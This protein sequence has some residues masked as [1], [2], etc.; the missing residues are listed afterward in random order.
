MS[1]NCCS[2]SVHRFKVAYKPVSLFCGHIGLVFKFAH[3]P[4]VCHL[5]PKIFTVLC[6]IVL[7]V[8]GSRID[9]ERMTS[10][11]RQKDRLDYRE[12]HRTGR[13]VLKDYNRLADLVSSMASEEEKLKRKDKSL[14]LSITECLGENAL[15]MF[16]DVEDIDDCVLEMKSLRDRYRNVHVDLECEIGEEYKARFSRDYTEMTDRISEYIKAANS[17]KKFVRIQ[18]DEKQYEREKQERFEIEERNLK[19]RVDIE[20]KLKDQQLEV[21]E[22]LRIEENEEKLKQEDKLAKEKLVIVNFNIECLNSIKSTLERVFGSDLNKEDDYEILEKRKNLN[23]IN[24]EFRNFSEISLEILKYFPSDL[25]YKGLRGKISEE[26]TNLSRLHSI[27]IVELQEEVTK[28]DLNKE[29]LSPMSVLNIK[30]D[31][32]T[33]YDSAVDIYTF[34]DNFEKLY[35]SVTQKKRL[36]DLLKNNYLDGTAL[37]LVK[38]IE[39]IDEIWKRLK[40]AFGNSELLLRKKLYETEKCGPIWKIREPKGLINA[41]SKL[42]NAMTDL[43]NLAAKHSIENDLY[44]SSTFNLMY[45]LIGEFR[46]KKFISETIGQ[47]LCKKEKWKKLQEFLVKEI[48]IL[49]EILL[50]EKNVNDNEKKEKFKKDHSY[51]TQDKASEVKLKCHICGKNDHKATKDFKNRD[52]IQYFACKTFVEMSPKERFEKLREK[53]LCHQC[54]APGAY[55]KNDKRSYHKSGKCF[56]KFVCKDKLHNKYNQK[57]HVLVC[58]EHKNQ[59]DDLFEKYKTAEIVGKIQTLEDFSKQIKLSY[60]SGANEP[61]L[62]EENMEVKVPLYVPPP[63]RC[64]I[65]LERESK[66]LDSPNNSLSVL[67]PVFKSKRAQTDKSTIDSCEPEQTESFIYM[68]QR[69]IVGNNEFS[70]FFDSGCGDLVN[71]KSAVDK[72]GSDAELQVAGPL[73]LNGV[74]NVRTISRHGI[75]RITLPLYNGNK[76]ILCGITLD[77]VTARFPTYTLSGKVQDDIHREFRSSGGNPINLPKLFKKVGGETDFMLGIKYLKYFPREVFY[78]PSGLTIYESVFLNPDGSRGV[79]GGPHSVFTAIEQQYGNFA[80]KAYLN[81]QLIIV[82]QGYQINPDVSLLNVKPDK[83]LQKDSLSYGIKILK[84][85]KAF[86]NIENAGT[87][88]NYRC[89]SCRNCADCKKGERIEL[90]SL[91]DEYEQNLIDKSIEVDIVKGLTLARLPFVESPEKLVPNKSQALS[92]YRSQVNKL[93]R[94]PRIRKI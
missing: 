61:V 93:N 3:K 68:L 66:K 46:K 69:I 75:H 22:K 58:E 77:Q 24:E 53:D 62:K 83:D 28:R 5:Y 23:V 87:E 34:Q 7:I 37:V 90:I 40:R 88:V 67:A 1:R 12:L 72:L 13:K 8:T 16:E 4:V 54:L 31:K 20:Q 70:I 15:E 14:A 73:T 82:N 18:K 57:K 48:S 55:M 38:E 45:E 30:L 44:H 65:Q 36:P 32:F 74:G 6:P 50:S 2:I 41:L 29:K 33:G 25:D 17:K 85:Q 39:C 89:I 27:Y 21:N 51:F 52:V 9:F 10:R 60:H 42:N 64:I 81:E 63:L 49:E 76:A 26:Y 43:G 35:L 94:N 79:V 47:D 91:Q 56:S 80:S 92:A 84:C 59:N 86:E 71:K 11:Y 19:A 78:L